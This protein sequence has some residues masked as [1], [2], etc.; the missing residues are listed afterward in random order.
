VTVPGG[1]PQGYQDCFDA[2]V[3]EAYAAF[4]GEDPADGMPQL[5]DG[6]RAV[7]IT[8]AVVESAKRRSWVDLAN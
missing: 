2:F 1:H 3:A 4:S 5:D 7:R 6:L 8:E